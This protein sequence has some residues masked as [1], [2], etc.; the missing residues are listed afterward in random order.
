M[1]DARR[2]VPSH[3]EAW[4]W[5]LRAACRRMDSQFFFHPDGERG[6]AREQREACAKAVCR[7]CPVVRECRAHALAVRAP[8]GIWGGLS[9]LDRDLIEEG[10]G[11][12]KS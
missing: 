6:P 3:G 9:R 10:N 11:A 8:Y 1:P 7:S 5:Q 2:S 12:V 4:D